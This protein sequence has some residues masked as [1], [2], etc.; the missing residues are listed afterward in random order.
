MSILNTKGQECPEPDYI[1]ME[2]AYPKESHNLERNGEVEI[3][4]KCSHGVNI[5][6]DEFLRVP[7]SLAASSKPGYHPGTKETLQ[8]KDEG[9]NTNPATFS[10]KLIHSVTIAVIFIFIITGL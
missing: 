4:F 10:Y 6:E 2:P 7:S 3:C 8:Y 9:K 1:I 5:Y